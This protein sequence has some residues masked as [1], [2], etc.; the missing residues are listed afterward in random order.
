MI[1][2]LIVNQ[3]CAKPIPERMKDKA[4]HQVD[5][6]AGKFE[7]S[8]YRSFW[9]VENGDPREKTQVEKDEDAKAVEIQRIK[10]VAKDGILSL[11]EKFTILEE[12]L[13]DLRRL[14][15][16]DIEVT[17]GIQIKKFTEQQIENRLTNLSQQRHQIR[18]DEIQ[19]IRDLG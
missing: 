1:R 2:Y 16:P 13:D 4:T 12:A 3:D 14:N 11:E 17:D 9:T 15:L 7:Q 5:L 19:A 8:A 18:L 6:P 10:N